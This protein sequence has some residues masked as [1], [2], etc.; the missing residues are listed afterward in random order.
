MNQLRQRV[1]GVSYAGLCEINANDYSP[2]AGVDAYPP[3]QDSNFFENRLHQ[4][5]M[6]PIEEEKNQIPTVKN[7][8]KL[9][10]FF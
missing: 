4:A 7:R 10:E 9:A 8:E 6:E 3:G 2:K 5:V 1:K